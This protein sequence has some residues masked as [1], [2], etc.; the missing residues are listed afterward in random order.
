MLLDNIGIALTALKSNKLRSLLTMLG[1]VIGISAVIAIMIVG[2]AVNNKM[3][4]SFNKFGANNVNFYVTMK[5]HS[6]DSYDNYRE[7]KNKDYVSEEILTDLNE[8]FGDR[9]DGI[10]LNNEVGSGELSVRSKSASVRAMGINAAWFASNNYTILAGRALNAND[11]GKAAKTALISDKAAKKL[12]GSNYENAVGKSVEAMLNDK[13]FTY[14]VVGIYEYQNQYYYG[15]FG[16]DSTDLYIPLRTSFSQ[17][18]SDIL[19]NSFSLKAAD[20][21]EQNALI[22]EIQT[23][24]NN[25]YYGSNDFYN[26]EGDGM[27]SYIDE[28]KDSLNKIKIA[29]A[30]IAAISLLVG[31]IGVMNIMIVSIT[32]RTREIG[33]RKALGAENGSIRAQFI[34]E[35]I[36]ICLIG[37][38]IGILLGN[39]LGALASKMLIQQAGTASVKAVAGCVLF[40]VAFGVFFGYY[41]ANKAAKLNPIDALRYE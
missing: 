28:S 37:G 40:S 11:Y 32:E 18:N 21:E 7:M 41:P 35:A 3:I 38:I 30:A 17:T 36:V 22:D 14:T 27:Q 23:Y 10:M 9:L 12:F 4:D 6:E 15:G 16:E 13:V 26:V 8:H 20:G 1:I 24:I 31:G 39:G 25:R 19:F 29:I 2:D 5:D 34:T 33:T